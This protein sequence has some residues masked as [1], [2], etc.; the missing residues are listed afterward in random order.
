MGIIA[1][2]TYI[3]AVIA[4]VVLAIILFSK[5]AQ[6]TA[7]KCATAVCREYTSLLASS[8]NASVS[9]C[10]SFTRFV[11][12]GWERSQVLSVREMLYQRAQDHMT[13]RV[14]TIRVPPSGQNS[15]QRAAAVYSSCEQVLS[16][17]SDHLAEIKRALAA[18]GIT[19]PYAQGHAN[20]LRTLMFT[21]LNLA[22]DVIARV[23][24]EQ[25]GNRTTLM[26]NPGGLFYRILEQAAYTASGMSFKAYFTN[27]RRSFGHG[28]GNV[29]EVSLAETVDLEKTVV[30]SL[31]PNYYVRTLSP[32][33]LIT[34]SGIGI[35]NVDWLNTFR[36]LG[37]ND[38]AA[39]E[40]VT[41]G[42][43]FI[44]AFFDIWQKNGDTYAHLLASWTTVQVAALFANKGLIVNYYGGNE[45]VASARYGAFCLSVAYLLSPSAL[46][47]NHESEFDGRS[48][49]ASAERVTRAIADAFQRRLARWPHFKKDITVV[50]NWAELYSS[51][52][53]FGG[54]RH[55]THSYIPL[56]MT[57]SLL[58]NWRALSRIAGNAVDEEVAHSISSLS[59][60]VAFV[61]ERTF[62]LTP[63]SVSFPMFD[64]RL[65]AAVNYGGLG[66]Q[67]ASALAWLLT[68]AY[69]LDSRTSAIIGNLSA[70]VEEDS[71]QGFYID[72]PL[73]R[74]VAADAL[75][76]AY[77]A[78][79]TSK[80]RPFPAPGLLQRKAAP[81]HVPVLRQLR[82]K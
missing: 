19:W 29:K 76:E 35:S 49:R 44:G 52:I 37:H 17:H 65:P 6:P 31:V 63:V 30:S 67:V 74:A 51:V 82:R 62:R 50:A 12:G 13:R 26:V 10:H 36:Q 47:G 15:I 79:A 14:K 3:F 68:T 60:S 11:C 57:H 24:P 43:N 61:N 34:P 46:F 28:R 2:L 5:G 32:V 23:V 1:L 73:S 25:S 38:T 18:A 33:P 70:C 53:P 8:I 81:L 22:W 9:P 16:G 48:T 80:R 71:S 64:V 39:V 27:L 72:R 78:D 7:D 4:A 66:G 42:P 58:E 75:I 20:L 54:R 59:L 45:K 21:S 41:T 40:V 69:A 77:E 55:H 56:D